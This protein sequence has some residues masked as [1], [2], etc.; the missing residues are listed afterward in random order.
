MIKNEL[1]EIER[2]EKR[3]E[4]D[5]FIIKMSN[6]LS[7]TKYLLNSKTENFSRELQ[8]IEIWLGDNGAY[9]KKEMYTNLRN[10]IEFEFERV[11]KSDKT[12]KEISKK[13]KLMLEV[14]KKLTNVENG[15]EC[16]E[17]FEVL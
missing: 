11:L 12:L 3:N 4:L 15:I 8:N 17:S 16:D 14:V 13:M 2:V 5:E 10:K 1:K 7:S 9:K 6:K